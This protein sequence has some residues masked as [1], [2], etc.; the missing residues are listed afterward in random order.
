MSGDRVGYHFCLCWHYVLS[1]WR[2][3]GLLNPEGKVSCDCERLLSESFIS[4]VIEFLVI[5]YCNVNFT[6]RLISIVTHWKKKVTS[7][8]K[9]H[10]DF[11]FDVPT[12]GAWELERWIARNVGRTNVSGKKCFTA[13]H[14]DQQWQFQPLLERN[15]VF[16][17]HHSTRVSSLCLFLYTD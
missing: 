7:R 15:N 9:E 5:D 12:D 17:H 6:K 1:R 2:R 4:A 3:G 10:F 14:G 8:L 11:Y 16:F 13:S